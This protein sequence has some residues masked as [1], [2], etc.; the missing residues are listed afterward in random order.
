MKGEPFLSNIEIVAVTN[1]MCQWQGM[2]W[3]SPGCCA[4]DLSRHHYAV[5]PASASSVHVLTLSLLFSVICYRIGA[6]S[7]ANL[8]FSSQQLMQEGAASIAD[9]LRLTGTLKAP[10]EFEPGTKYH[11]S[12]PGYSLAG[13]I[14]EKVSWFATAASTDC[15]VLSL[16]CACGSGSTCM[17]H[18]VQHLKPSESAGHA[19]HPPSLPGLMHA[20]QCRGPAAASATCS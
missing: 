15:A 2:L 6:K 4:A 19:T 5:A 14:V 7:P 13:Y 9:Y 12:N 20:M 3:P 17:V 10:L 8:S 18:V 11:Y 16:P 1:P